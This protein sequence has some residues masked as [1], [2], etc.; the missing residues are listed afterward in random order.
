[1]FLKLAFAF[2][3]HCLCF[4]VF[5]LF[6]QTKGKKCSRTA[7]MN[8]MVLNVLFLRKPREL[9]RGL[10]LARLEN[11]SKRFTQTDLLIILHRYTLEH[12]AVTQHGMVAGAKH[13]SRVTGQ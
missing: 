10:S 11:Q 5:V 7:N 4:I 12:T 2:F 6:I 13:R 1:M 9:R 8:G 3:I